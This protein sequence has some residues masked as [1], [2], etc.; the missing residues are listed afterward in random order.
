MTI[1]DTSKTPV[2]TLE[3]TASVVNEG[4]SFTIT[5]TTENVDTD[6]VIP[7]TIGG[8]QTEDIDNT[9]LT[10]SF[11]VGSDESRLFLV[12]DDSLVEVDE[13]FVITLTGLG[14]SQTVTIVG[15][16]TSVIDSGPETIV[17]GDAVSPFAIVDSGPETIVLGT[18]S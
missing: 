17:L 7:Y 14:V 10:G 18:S 15:V 16:Q 8:V 3:S 11:T 9:S 6:T 1:A 5:L 2:Y 4:E 13:D 12:T